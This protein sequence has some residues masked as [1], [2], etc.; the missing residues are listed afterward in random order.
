[1]QRVKQLSPHDNIL[2]ALSRATITQIQDR[3]CQIREREEAWSERILIFYSKMHSFRVKRVS[4]SV[5]GTVRFN[6]RHEF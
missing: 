5:G 1:M 4:R 3:R 2:F 6:D